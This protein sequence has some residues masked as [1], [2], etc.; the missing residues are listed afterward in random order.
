LQ[1]KDKKISNLNASL[2]Q[3]MGFTGIPE[4]PKKWGV[5]ALNLDERTVS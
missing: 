2:P 1:R 3:K 5:S 4:K